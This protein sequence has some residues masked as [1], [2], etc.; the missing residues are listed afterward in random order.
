MNVPFRVKICGIT[1][2]G[3]ALA[4]ADAG[5]DAIGFN[6]YVKSPRYIP[7]HK[8]ALIAKE[9]PASVQVVGLFVN[10]SVDEITHS[11]EELRLDMIQLQGDE[12]P[13]FLSKLP[14]RSILKAFRFDAANAPQ[15]RDF[16][17]E[18]IRF[19]RP[20]VAVLADAQVP[21]SY[22]GTGQ[23]CDWEAI[24]RHRDCFSG[25]PLVVAG[26]LTPTNVANAILETRCDAVDVA[27]GVESSP[28]R[29]DADRV[30]QF[31]EASKKA[32]STMAVDERPAG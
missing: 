27:S 16:L 19:G 23:A 2:P 20:P 10:S 12:H 7:L 13:S 28:G 18:C 8:A 17:S 4:V 3:D 1:S 32:F 25:I 29:K 9:L 15:I 11:I 6:F 30:R 22:G 26:G 21:G 31:V 24:A 14:N 5:A